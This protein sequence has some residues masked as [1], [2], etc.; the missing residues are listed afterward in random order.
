VAYGAGDLG[1]PGVDNAQCTL[2][3]PAG[4]CDSG[5]FVRKIVKPA[6][7]QLVISEFLANPANVT[8]ATD[9]QREWFEIANTGATSFDLNELAVGRVGATGAPVRSARCIIVP[10]RGYAV[11]ARSNDPAANSML[12][13]VNATFSFGLVDTGGD[14]QVSDGATVLD[15]VRWAS[16]T[17]GVTRQLDPA[18][19]T[20]TDN[21]VAASFCAGT[22][23]YGDL[24]N[25][26]SPGAANS[27]CP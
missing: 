5:G 14:I 25:K 24:T 16:V 13:A 23:P 1:T 8:G 26:G 10:P 4:M 19:L 17:S 7:G 18:H 27:P 15:V 21:D 20:A 3:P 12:P 11:F 22:A 2:L 6:P 9:A